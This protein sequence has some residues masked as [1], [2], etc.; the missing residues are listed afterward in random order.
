MCAAIDRAVSKHDY[1]G[2]VSG[3]ERNR[4]AEH[5][6]SGRR[7]LVPAGE[8]MT[9]DTIFDAASLTKVIACTPAVMLLIERGKIKLDDRAQTYI[10]EF[11][12]DGKEAITVRHLLTHTS[13]LPPDISTDPTWSGYDTAI[14]IACAG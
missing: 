2:A 5:E 8:P 3:I 11:K 7:A 1:P 12:G 14:S 10:P 9:E 13:G 6:G 4:A